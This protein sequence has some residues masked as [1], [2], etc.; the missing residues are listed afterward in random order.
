MKFVESFFKIL[1]AVDSNAKSG[2]ANPPPQ[3]STL[4]DLLYGGR[5]EA[6]PESEWVSLV[7]AVAAR[8]SHALRILFERTHR[9]VF[10]LAMRLSGSREIAEEITVDVFEE[11]WLRAPDFDPAGGTVIAWIMNQ[12]KSRSIDRLRYEH[13][14]KRQPRG[15]DRAG[16]D[17]SEAPAQESDPGDAVDARRRR[18]SLEDA[19]H[20]LTAEERIA[21]ETAFFSELTYAETATRLGHPLGTVK[22]RIRSALTKLRKTL[23]RNGGDP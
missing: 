22:T 8:D 7:R 15:G 9:L 10:T 1:A 5:P 4:G 23:S 20:E 3:P 11:I 14:Q 17:P 18:S 6:L 2:K 13:R 19:L 16:A 21:V 12:A